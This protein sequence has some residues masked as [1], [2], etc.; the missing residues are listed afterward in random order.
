MISASR[1]NTEIRAT[2]YKLL[3]AS[4]ELKQQKLHEERY[5]LEIAILGLREKILLLAYDADF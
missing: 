3:A 4:A 5:L 2:Y 1:I